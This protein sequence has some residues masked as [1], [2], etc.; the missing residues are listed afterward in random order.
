MGLEK[1]EHRRRLCSC[2]LVFAVVLSRPSAPSAPVAGVVVGGAALRA[3][4]AE[5]VFVEQE[6]VAEGVFVEQ[7]PVVE[8]EPEVVVSTEPVRQEEQEVVVSQA[9]ALMNEPCLLVPA[10]AAP[11][12]GGP[13]PGPWCFCRSRDSLIRCRAGAE[14]YAPGLKQVSASRVCL[15]QGERRFAR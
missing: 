12:R 13:V 3:P 15:G 10:C 8:W 11:N 14:A 7:E 6:P 4:A 9:G 1:S 5:A 2:A